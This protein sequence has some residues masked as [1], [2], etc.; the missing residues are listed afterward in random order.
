MKNHST[1]DSTLMSLQR[2]NFVLKQLNRSLH[3]ERTSISLF[4]DSNVE[5][6]LLPVIWNNIAFQKVILLVTNDL[7]HIFTTKVIECSITMLTFILALS[8]E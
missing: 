3:S 1:T 5:Q 7:L 6:C 2:I 4:C 8:L